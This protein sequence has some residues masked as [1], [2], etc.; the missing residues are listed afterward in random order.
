MRRYKKYA[1]GY[2]VLDGKKIV[3][4]FDN[5]ED[6]DWNYGSSS[7]YD[8]RWIDTDGNITKPIEITL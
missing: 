1:N 8:I 2:V 7:H 5:F 3:A 4:F 6:A